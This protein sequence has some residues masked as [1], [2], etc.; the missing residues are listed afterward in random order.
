[1]EAGRGYCSNIGECQN[2]RCGHKD[3]ELQIDS[4]AMQELEDIQLDVCLNVKENGVKGDCYSCVTF[5]GL[6]ATLMSLL[7]L[8]PNRMSSNTIL[9]MPLPCLK[10]F[11]GSHHASA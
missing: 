3:E 11:G 9:I 2:L 8:V 7:H 6:P 5:P 1:M 10:L 4:K